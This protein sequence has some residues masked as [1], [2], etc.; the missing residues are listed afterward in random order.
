MEYNLLSQKKLFFL[1]YI[2]YICYKKKTFGFMEYMY[3][4]PI[5]KKKILY[6]LVI[7]NIFAIQ[8]KKNFNFL[9]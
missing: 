8:K 6:F 3:F 4:I 1:G 2:E 5:N 9:V 7:W